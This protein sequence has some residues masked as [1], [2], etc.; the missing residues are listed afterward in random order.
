MLLSPT[1]VTPQATLETL[2]FMWEARQLL[3]DK[4]E[5]LEEFRT[6]DA[7]K[8]NEFIDLIETRHKKGEMKDFHVSMDYS[9]EITI[10]HFCDSWFKMEEALA[11][12]KPFSF[13]DSR[14]VGAQRAPDDLLKD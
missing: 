5:N 11:K 7:S 4:R 10:E 3:W 2:K 1:Y 13:D 8:T 9:K 14:F 12:R 6:P